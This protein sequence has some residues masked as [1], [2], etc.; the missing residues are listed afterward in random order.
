MS[1]ISNIYRLN[2]ESGN[3]DRLTSVLG[4]AYYPDLR[5]N[6]LVYSDFCENGFRVCTLTEPHPIRDLAGALDDTLA[7]AGTETLALAR[8]PYQA[9]IPQPTFALSA[10]RREGKPYKPSFEKLYWFPRIA[11]DYGTF[12]PGTYLLLNDVLE[13][14]SFLGGFA[15]NQKRDYD[16]FGMAEYRALYPTIF[17][18]YYNIQRRL[19]AHFSDST[20]IVGEDPEVNPI[21]DTYRIRYRYSLNEIDGGLRVP[22]GGSTYA[23]L[24]GVYD[25]YNAHN[26]FDDGV[27]IGITYFKGWSGKL[28]LY[29]DQRRP[30]ISLGNQPQRR[31]QGL[32]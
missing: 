23:K 7:A 29:T 32:C 27:S 12:K 30:G 11:F 18:E 5:G 2:L 15:I 9:R 21:Y 26:R 3:R 25:R 6:R 14:L 16:L 10:P 20:R 19:T 24:M 31:I 17:V 13:K 4:G 28:G 22:L 1:G 8:S